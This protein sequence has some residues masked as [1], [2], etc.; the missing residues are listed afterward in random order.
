MELYCEELFVAEIHVGVL[1]FVSEKYLVVAVLPL[2]S[3]GD[4]NILEFRQIEIYRRSNIDEASSVIH[5]QVQQCE[6]NSS[7]DDFNNKNIYSNEI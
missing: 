1:S 6:D 3:A 7:L 5:L 2:S 4:L